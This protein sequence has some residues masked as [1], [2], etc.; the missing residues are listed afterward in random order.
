MESINQSDTKKI[1]N[2]KK[3]KLICVNF[4]NEKRNDNMKA[5]AAYQSCE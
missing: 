4:E 3:N 1:N 2:E 5:D